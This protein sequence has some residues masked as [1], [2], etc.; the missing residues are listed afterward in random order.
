MSLG[1]SSQRCEVWTGLKASLTSLG[2]FWKHLWITVNISDA[3]TSAYSGAENA[4][5]PVSLRVSLLLQGWATAC[6][7]VM[8]LTPS[9]APRMHIVG[10][11]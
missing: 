7:L 2:V 10:A 3:G 8:T 5:A 11:Q 1:V 6:L 9:T 4:D